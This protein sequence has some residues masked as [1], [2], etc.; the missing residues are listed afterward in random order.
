MRVV[1]NFCSGFEVKKSQYS[2]FCKLFAGVYG[3]YRNI[4]AG[5]PLNWVISRKICRNS[6]N[7]G[8]SQ[9]CFVAFL[10]GGL[11]LAV[12]FCLFGHL[13]SFI[14]NQK[15]N[16]F[17]FL[18]LEVFGSWH[19]SK[20][21]FSR[22]F[23]KLAYFLSIYVFTFLLLLSIPEDLISGNTTYEISS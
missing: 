6:L 5:P 4:K 8:S 18:Y 7:A 13:F 3:G 14:G 11:C 15:Q 1:N 16:L 12:E 22:L 19:L 17:L 20:T 10:R 9:P 21:L 2:L 23:S